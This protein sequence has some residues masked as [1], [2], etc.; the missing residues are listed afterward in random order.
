MK[1]LL[2]TADAETGITIR[3]HYRSIYDNVVT[4]KTIQHE[5]EWERRRQEDNQGIRDGYLAPITWRQAVKEW[6]A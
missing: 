5:R 2:I 1:R 3:H 4:L 6:E